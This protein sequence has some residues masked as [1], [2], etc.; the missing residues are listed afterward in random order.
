MY[1]S[2]EAARSRYGRTLAA[3]AVSKNGRFFGAIYIPVVYKN[4][5]FTY[6]DRLGTSIGKERS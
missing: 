1:S 4:E 6:Q 5:H 2:P 3:P